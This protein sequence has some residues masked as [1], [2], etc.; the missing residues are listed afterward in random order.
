MWGAGCFGR[1]KTMTPPHVHSCHWGQWRPLLRDDIQIPSCDK[2]Y[3]CGGPR[4]CGFWPRLVYKLQ[5]G[6]SRSALPDYMLQLGARSAPENFWGCFYSEK[7]TSYRW[8]GF[9]LPGTQLHVT[10]GGGFSPRASRTKHYN[11]EYG[12]RPLSYMGQLT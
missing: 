3:R 4:F 9:S 2:A 1:C 5:E 10:G 12:W 7:C 11:L 8:G 6:G